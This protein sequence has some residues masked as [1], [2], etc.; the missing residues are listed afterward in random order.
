MS[1]DYDVIVIGGGAAGLAAARHSVAIGATTLLVQQGPVGGDCT[2]TGCVPSK[3]VIEAAAGG[4]GFD[5][6]MVAARRAIGTI[7]ATEDDD[8]IHEE[9]IDLLHGWA[10]FVSPREV[11]CSGRR[12]GAT[13]FVIATG[14]RPAI[15]PI[16]GIGSVDYLT[17][18]TIFDLHARP[19]DLA[20]L[21]G[22]AVGCEMGQAL[23]RL[24]SRVTIIELADRVLPSEEPE[25][26]AVIAAT[27]AGEGIVVRTGRRTVRADRL[28]SGPGPAGATTRL[29]FDD[30]SD[31]V[32]DRVLVAAGRDPS[33]AG[34]GLEA[35]GVRT[36]RDG[37]V[38]TDRHLATTG[39]GIWAAGDVTGRMLTT[40][41]A[42][43]MGRIAA[44]NAL[45]RRARRWDD[46]AVPT[47]TFTD[48]E[49]G[50][51]GVSEAASARAGR[52][53]RVAYLP[54]SEVDRAVIAGKTGGFVKLVA[55]PRPVV[56]HRGGGRLVGATVVASRGGE[57]IHEAA[58]A[59]RTGMFAG[60]LAQTVHAYPTWSVAMR[61]AAA[62][63]V[64]DTGPRR[65]RPAGGG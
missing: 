45:S 52:G 1:A 43:E 8:A 29:S 27:F 10:T 25:A 63:L 46:R 16:E 6:A 42:D 20:V 2:F 54:M 26:S 53:A 48:P 39:A 13:R 61:Q 55:R 41:A 65:S 4:H 5:D 15:P 51:V 32:V 11:D 47:V 56:G 31:L 38:R 18:E 33:V 22:G 44:H 37:F 7:A 24:G 19:D 34:L 59:V 12:L 35:A 23:G 57:L 49:V 40:H 36:D 14:S 30:G 3:A 9:G 28:S 60:R 50:S 17:N 64:V 58:L 62:Q 21:G